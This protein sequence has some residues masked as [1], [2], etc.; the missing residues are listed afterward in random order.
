MNESEKLCNSYR[1]RHV[2]VLFVGESP[3][4]KGTF[5]YK[6]NSRLYHAMKRAFGDSAS[7]LSE[8]KAN[9]FFLDDL[10]ID[11]INQMEGPE[12]SEHR[13]EGVPSLA[14]RMKR[15]QPSAVVALM[16]ANKPMV[17]EAMR[18]AGLSHVPLHVTPFP[19]YGNQ[20]RFRAKM[21]EI[22]P[23]ILNRE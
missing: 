8:F 18:R 19:T 2:T 9:G 12:R 7:F 23:K 6:G 1:P 5:F 16:C 11:P 17:V 3:P 21:A 10:V 13:K 14:Q 15:Y 22:M 20:G 4:N